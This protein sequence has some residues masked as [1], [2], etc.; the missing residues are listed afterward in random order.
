MILAD[1]PGAKQPRRP[2]DDPRRRPACSVGAGGIERI[3]QARR[4]ASRGKQGVEQQ[5]PVVERPF[6]VGGQPFVQERT[7]R[8]QPARRKRL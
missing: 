6:D 3:A 1:D 4:D 8:L 7:Q 5:R 2:G